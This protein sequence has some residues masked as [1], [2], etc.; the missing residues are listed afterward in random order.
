[1]FE[2]D[3]NDFEGCLEIMRKYCGSKLPFFGTNADGENVIISVNAS[4]I[5]VQTMQKNGWLRTNVL[6][7]DGTVEERYDH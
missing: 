4:N 1:M 5:T 3:F 2:V 6:W 7:E